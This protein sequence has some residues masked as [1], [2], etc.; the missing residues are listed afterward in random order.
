MSQNCQYLFEK[1]C[2]YV[3]IGMQLKSNH[4]ILNLCSL[5]V[6]LVKSFSKI[7]KNIT[8]TPT[9]FSEIF[10]ILKSMLDKQMF[11]GN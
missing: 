7:M 5:K 3:N 10:D 11:T 8:P 4:L 9:F 2:K 6:V 1:Y